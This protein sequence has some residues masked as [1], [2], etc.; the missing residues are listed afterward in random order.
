MIPSEHESHELKEGLLRVF[1]KRTEAELK[2]LG[3]MVID[4]EK[5]VL[6]ALRC[7]VAMRAILLSDRHYRRHQVE[8]DQLDCPV[9][10]APESQMA[11]IVG[12]RIHQ[13]MMAIAARPVQ[14][15]TW[16]DRIVI[17]EGLTDAQNV[18][19]VVRNAHAFGFGTLLHD[20][21][22]CSPFTR[23]SIRVSMGSIFR[24]SIGQSDCLLATAAQ[25]V[26]RGYQLVATGLWPGAKTLA[27]IAPRQRLAVIIGNEDQGVSEALAA[28]CHERAYIPM[29]NGIDSLSAT[30]A[31]AVALYHLGSFT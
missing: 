22:T 29:A 3:L 26:E 13:G 12:H 16:S 4:S 2:P 10:I 9:V 23:R 19:S 31:A 24:S 11:E 17:L 30:S 20:R 25:L 18:G 27:D 6:R 21:F 5:V 14:E 15:C 1:A 28:L 7:G 8:L